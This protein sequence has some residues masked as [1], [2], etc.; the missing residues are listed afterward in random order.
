ML[1]IATSDLGSDPLTEP[2]N[3]VYFCARSSVDPLT[4]LP[5]PPRP[6]RVSTR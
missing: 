5:P 6:I 3:G 1:G 2:I 4:D